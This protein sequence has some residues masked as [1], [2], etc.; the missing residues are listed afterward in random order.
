MAGCGVHLGVATTGGLDVTFRAARTVPGQVR[1][2]VE[3]RLVEWGQAG[4][5]DD[6]TLIASEL[7]TNAVCHTSGKEIRVRFTREPHGVL[8]QVWDGSDSMPARGRAVETVADAAVPDAA[9]L[10]AGHQ[11]G[12]G[13][14]GLPIVEALA[15]RWGVAP[16]EPNGKWTWAR[17]LA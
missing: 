11:D 7:V 2:L 16:T 1:T 4:L 3:L 14:R 10:E 6:V 5:V 15:H 17:V 9:A 12:T 8:L 13:G